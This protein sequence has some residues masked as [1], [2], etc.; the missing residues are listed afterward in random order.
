MQVFATQTA[1][2]C[3]TQDSTANSVNCKPVRI[4]VPRMELAT[5]RRAIVTA[6]TIT[7]AMIAAFIATAA[8]VVRTANA[9]R[10]VF[11]F[12]NLLGSDMVAIFTATALLHAMIKARAIQGARA[13]VTRPT[14]AI[15][16]STFNV[17]RASRTVFATILRATATA[18]HTISATIAIFF[19]IQRL[20]EFTASVDRTVNACAGRVFTDPTATLV[21]P[22][23]TANL[24]IAT[25]PWAVCATKS[26]SE[27]TATSSASRTTAIMARVTSPMVRVFATTSTTA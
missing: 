4:I 23:I 11:V 1:R 21:V 19:A 8:R 24:V 17:P 13:I 15:T 18:H 16:A 25:R 5:A 20:A 14:T 12:A 27:W 26:I 2:A 9:I 3:V 7:L 6:T 10:M 22:L